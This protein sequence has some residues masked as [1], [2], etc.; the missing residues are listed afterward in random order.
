MSRRDDAGNTLAVKRYR[1]GEERFGWDIGQL[2]KEDDGDE[3]GKAAK[4]RVVAYSDSD[5]DVEPHFEQVRTHLLPG[6][7]SLDIKADGTVAKER[8]KAKTGEGEEEKRMAS[9]T[10]GVGEDSC[11]ELLACCF[12]TIPF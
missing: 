10:V 1:Q 11:P 6:I 8:E 7:D 12:P 5:S 3:E 4:V 2:R 9:H